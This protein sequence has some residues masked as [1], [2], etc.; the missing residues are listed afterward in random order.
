MTT[1][2][3]DRRPTTEAKL[4]DVVPH[5]GQRKHGSNK[6]CRITD[7]VGVQR[8]RGTMRRLRALP[9]CMAL[10]HTDDRPHE[11]KKVVLDKVI[12]V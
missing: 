10:R 3:N 5:L 4:H 12:V 11:K 1:E 6:G 9:R 7:A 2:F 8:R